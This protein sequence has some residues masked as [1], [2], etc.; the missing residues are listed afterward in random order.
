MSI[1]DRI[2]DFVRGTL[3]A[4]LQ[5][6]N[7][8]LPLRSASI[9]R[10]HLIPVTDCVFNFDIHHYRNQIISIREERRNNSQFQCVTPTLLIQLFR[11]EYHALHGIWE[12]YIPDPGRRYAV[13]NPMRCGRMEPAL[14]EA[15]E[16]ITFTTYDPLMARDPDG[17][18]LR[19]DMREATYHFQQ[20]AALDNNPYQHPN[21]QM[22]I[23]DRVAHMPSFA[24]INE[25]RRHEPLRL[26]RIQ[27]LP[28]FI[29]RPRRT[30]TEERAETEATMAAENKGWQLLQ[31]NLNQSQREMLE[32]QKYFEVIGGDTKRLYRIY[33]GKS[34]NIH[35]ILP[36]GLVE[37]RI[38]FQPKGVLVTGDV[39]L[40]QKLA[41]ELRE[42][43]ALKVANYFHVQGLPAYNERIVQEARRMQAEYY[44]QRQ[45]NT[46]MTT[47]APGRI[48]FWNW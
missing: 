29:P 24:P 5:Q 38:C 15:A 14:L 9:A 20:L 42:S 41:L 7:A 30:E 4:E 11:L 28:E 22:R 8:P 35:L 32:K 36:N 46:T 19:E 21:F 43:D 40:T 39:M 13:V 25:P 23:V 18:Q 37:N 34:Y 26:N 33:T 2:R 48:N 27:H 1:L 16:A 17:E 6:G 12:S 3:A 47:G 31:D 10:N 45:Q 44:Y